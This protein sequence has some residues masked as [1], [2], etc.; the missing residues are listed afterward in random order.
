L[1]ARLDRTTWSLPPLFSWLQSHGRV[2]DDEMLRVFNYGIGM[3]LVV[4]EEDADRASHLLEAH[5]EIVS[6]IGMIDRRHA[7]E[8]QT[9]VA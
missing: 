7:D 1:T 6:R 3:V 8:P 5:G 9:I 2:A 4:S